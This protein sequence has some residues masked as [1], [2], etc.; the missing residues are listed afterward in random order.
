M[1]IR[2]LAIFEIVVLVIL[3]RVV[4]FRSLYDLGNNIISFGSQYFNIL[5]RDGLLLVIKVKYF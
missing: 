4:K 5:I 2:F 1:A 3:F